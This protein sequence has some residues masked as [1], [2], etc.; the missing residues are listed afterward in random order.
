MSDVYHG[1]RL[2]LCKPSKKTSIQFVLQDQFLIY[3]LEVRVFKS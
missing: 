2:K 1:R 3:L